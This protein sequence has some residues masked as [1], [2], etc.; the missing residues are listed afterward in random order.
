MHKVI[1][2]LCWTLFVP[3]V[4]G[5][6]PAASLIDCPAVAAPVNGGLIAD[7]ANPRR[8]KYFNGG[9]AF[10]ASVG[11]PEGFLYRG[12]KNANGTRSGDQNAIINELQ[13]RGLNSI[14]VIG[15]NDSRYG[16]DGP[17]DGNPSSM[18][19]NGQIDVDILN[20]WYSWFQTLD[21]AGIVVIFSLY[22]DLIDV[23][24][25]KRM[26][27]DLSGGNLHPQEQK[28]VDAVVNK[29]K[30]LKN[31]IWVINE[32][33]NKT[34]PSNYVERW[35][36][37]A[38]RIRSLDTF[39][40]P[41]RSASWLK[42]I[43]TS[44]PTPACPCISTIRI[45]IRSSCNM[46]SRPLWSTCTTKCLRNGTRPRER[47]TFCSPKPGRYTTEPMVGRRI[48]RPRWLAPTSTRRTGNQ[49]GCG[50]SGV[51]GRRPECAG[52]HR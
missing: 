47:S 19:I 17:A 30:T 1:R 29:F 40:H 42:R 48:G 18:P 39:L 32:S 31:L 24:A 51:A 14:F 33:A 44:L 35:K 43:R 21:A 37:I 52:T 36:K 3:L 28:Y 5:A 38:A 13:A 22:D 20:Q 27:W 2:R 12:T 8:L 45:S 11:E 9:P 34:Y 6:G 49:V 4:A 41:Y 16:G 26:N 25:G 7:P 10:I 46:Y 50:T 15:F 23:L